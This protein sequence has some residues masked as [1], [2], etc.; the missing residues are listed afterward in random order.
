MLQAGQPAKRKKISTA[1]NIALPYYQRQLQPEL[2]RLGT[3][4]VAV[5]PQ[6]PERLVEIKRRH[7]LSFL[8]ASDK[9]NALGRRFGVT[10]TSDEAS[11]RAALAK[12]RSLGEVTGTGTWELPMP[13]VVVIGQDRVVRFV[14]VAPDWLARTEAEPVLDAVRALQAT[15]APQTIYEK[16]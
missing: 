16:A 9:D 2:E 3:T 15:A 4:L 5:S 14:D 6:V 1:C 12:G 7:D 8:V 11:Q 13:T 10:F